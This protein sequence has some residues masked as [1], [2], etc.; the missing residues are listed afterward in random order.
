MKKEELK[1]GEYYHLTDHS[2]NHTWIFKMFGHIAERDSVSAVFIRTTSAILSLND[3]TLGVGSPR[4]IREATAFEKRWLD[5]C[6]SKREFVPEKT[7]PFVT[8]D[9]VV[10]N[11]PSRTEEKNISFFGHFHNDVGEVIEAGTYYEVRVPG[12][13]NKG[14]SSRDITQYSRYQLKPFIP[15]PEEEVEKDEWEILNKPEED[16]SCL[17]DL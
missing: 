8:G 12:R 15:C 11:V 5:A 10:I 13:Q 17:N 16:F 6:I 3:E 9:K 2:M 14:I 1:I 7:I 4:I